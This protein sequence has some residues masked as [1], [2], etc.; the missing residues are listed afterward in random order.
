LKDAYLGRMRWLARSH[1]EMIEAHAQE[2]AEVD[3]SVGPIESA[4]GPP[5]E[6]EA[7]P[8]PAPQRGEHQSVPNPSVQPRTVPEAGS[9]QP[10][11]AS[12]DG[13]A[14]GVAPSGAASSEPLRSDP[15]QAPQAS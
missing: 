11:P 7:A 4:S 3:A 14:A 10:P 15:T 6:S 13:A 9:Q 2:F 5:R 12:P 1:L 8:P